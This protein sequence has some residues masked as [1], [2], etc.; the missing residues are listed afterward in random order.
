MKWLLR[1]R[2][3]PF[4][5]LMILV[6]ALLAGLRL[7]MMQDYSVMLDCESC[8]VYPSLWY[9]VQ[10]LLG[11][12]CAD[13]L[14]RRWAPRMA[15]AVRVLI[16]GVLLICAL[17]G[18]VLKSF[19]VRLDWREALKFWG[20]LDAGLFFLR[21]LASHAWW[22][23][24]AVALGAAALLYA[25]VGYVFERRSFPR[26]CLWVSGALLAL[27]VVMAPQ[28]QYHDIYV[29][30]ALAAFVD[31]PSLHR[32]YSA[33]WVQ[34][35]TP[36]LRE[37]ATQRI[38]TP[39]PVMTSRP[40]QVVLVVVES[41]SSYQSQAF[42]GIHDWTPQLDRWSQK[43]R[44]FTHFLANGKTTEDG[45]FALLTGRAPILQSGR[46]TIY[47]SDLDPAR[48]ALPQLLSQ[49]GYSTA[50]LTTG[51]LGFMQKGVWLEQV[52]FQTISGHDDPFYVGMPRYHFDAAEDS[53][54]YARAVQWMQQQSQQPYFLVLET[55]SSHQPYFDPVAKKPSMEGAFRYTDDAL[56]KFLDQ[57]E[58]D[59]F[60]EQGLVIVTGDHRAMVPASV[61]EREALGVD[62]LSRVPLLMLGASAEVA[63]ESG[64]FSQL[65]LLP[66]LQQLLLPGQ[67]CRYTGQG[68]WN[69]GSMAPASCTFMVRAQDP[70]K[71]FVQCGE[72]VFQV[73]LDAEHT[74]YRGLQGPRPYL[75]AIHV[76]RVPVH[77]K[78]APEGAAIP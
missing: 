8:L 16:L 57:L 15:W 38:C 24:A 59:G 56:G 6:F 13:L 74:Q 27:S 44:R 53:A 23:V 3:I 33:A 73:L 26:S 76:Q 19:L 72:Q 30:H 71:E 10:L 61:Q 43:G 29:R 68:I 50:F 69:T 2:S 14:A 58:S 75:D 66:S 5:A 18:W 12:C 4:A 37:A 55:V 36:R 32:E 21:L 64:R 60:L 9:E 63:Q 35:Q 11:L 49:Q 31:P 22:K 77:Q 28:R 42:G 65:D 78:P 62:H 41:L 46:R 67:T 40:A 7:V 1:G 25:L 54:L 39:E 20:D 47:E 45:L 17:D 34:A 52:G 51:N 48:P 70:D